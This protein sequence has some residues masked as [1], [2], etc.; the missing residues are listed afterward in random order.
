MSESLS[1]FFEN[2]III[3]V[4]K[5]ANETKKIF[6]FLFSFMLKLDDKVNKVMFILPK[7]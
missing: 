3:D 4:V 5:L 7:F 1:V 6:N 2:P